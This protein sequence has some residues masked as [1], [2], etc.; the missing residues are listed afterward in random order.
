MAI[1]LQRITARLGG[2]PT[3]G[4]RRKVGKLMCIDKVEVSSDLTD[5]SSGTAILLAVGRVCLAGFSPSKLCALAAIGRG[6]SN[7]V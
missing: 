5:G 3:P 7:W 2:S 4:G 6:R 1:R